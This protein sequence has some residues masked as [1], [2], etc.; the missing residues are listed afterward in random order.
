MSNPFA[1]E[2]TEKKSRW[3]GWL[4]G[5][6]IGYAAVR[7]GKGAYAAYIARRAPVVVRAATDQS[8]VLMAMPEFRARVQGNKSKEEI[9]QIGA[10][11]ARD[12]RI[13]LDDASLVTLS[14]VE[15]RLLAKMDTVS[16][17]AVAREGDLGILSPDVVRRLGRL[18]SA[19]THAWAELSIKAMV[20][21]LKQFPAQ[22]VSDADLTAAMV[23]LYQHIPAEERDRFT[24]AFTDPTHAADGEACW[25]TRTLHQRMQELDP[26]TR[27]TLARGLVQPA[28]P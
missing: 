7:G 21:E 28:A 17:A 16:C 3:I 13:R 26:P 2:G 19:S 24:Q 11:L 4:V 5:L 23:A 12:G 22:R 15:G 10:Q 20:A 25:A 27:R 18:D 8:D 14:A 1:P 9:R 6:A